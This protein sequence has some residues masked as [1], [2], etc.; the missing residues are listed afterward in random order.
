MKPDISLAGFINSLSSILKLRNIIFVLG[1]LISL[2]IYYLIADY[3]APFKD[4]LNYLN[5]DDEIYTFY[6]GSN[7]GFYHEIGTELNRL[8]NSQNDYDV[9][10]VRINLAEPTS[11]GLDNAVQVLS[12]KK[13][14]G[15]I[16]EST[17]RLG[18]ELRE[19]INYVSP[20]YMERL[21]I[22]CRKSL[23][24]P[25]STSNK[26][27]ELSRSNEDLKEILFHKDSKISIGEVGSGTRVVASYLLDVLELTETPKEIYSYSQT[28]GLAA[29]KD[30]S[31]NVFMVI[32]GAPLAQYA[33]I[34]EP[35]SEF[36]LIGISPT[37]IVEINDKFSTNYRVSNFKSKYPDYENINT[38]GSYSYLIS[39]KD[40]D[41]RMNIEM[42]RRIDYISASIKKNLEI[43]SWKDLKFQLDEIDFNSGVDSRETDINVRM[44][45]NITLFIVSILISTFF[46]IWILIW[47]FSSIKLARYF[48]EMTLIYKQYYPNPVEINK[49]VSSE[50]HGILPKNGSHEINELIN[51]IDLLRKLKKE[52]RKDYDTGGISESHFRNLLSSAQLALHE[53]RS[54]LTRAIT[55]HIKGND[56]NEYRVTEKTITNFFSSSFLNK[57]QYQMLLDFIRNK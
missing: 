23:F 9:N 35:N 56:D 25:K 53:F 36:Q 28:D 32:V 10:N 18:D 17:L 24:N 54:A 43:K 46:A 37:L 22:I 31:I 5:A 8:N 11:G 52:V 38:L 30:S 34:L 29:L 49:G 3:Y 40:V 4:T 44:Y 16:Q 6:S 57:D 45:K 26:I 50:F 19:K 15:L 13:S 12:G 27:G 20:L 39:S 41:E 1:I 48:R 42:L 55:N 21:H 2:V 7:G 14:F 47:V 33:E 51:G